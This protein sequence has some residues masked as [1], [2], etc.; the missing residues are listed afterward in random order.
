MPSDDSRQRPIFELLGERVAISEDMAEMMGNDVDELLSRLEQF[1][2]L[3]A[4]VIDRLCWELDSYSPVPGGFVRGS[5]HQFLELQEGK[6]PKV[7]GDAWIALWTAFV[8]STLA[9][10]RLLERGLEAYDYLG[11]LS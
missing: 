5:G 7:P 11:Q 4:A 3:G 1:D 8:I 10:L 2:I 9:V 6:F